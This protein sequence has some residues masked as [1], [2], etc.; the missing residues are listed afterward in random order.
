MII[1]RAGLVTRDGE[2]PRKPLFPHSNK[3]KG[4][5]SHAQNQR[6]WSDIWWSGVKLTYQEALGIVSDE[7]THLDRLS[8]RKG[9]Y[10]PYPTAAKDIAHMP[11]LDDMF[12]VD[13]DRKNYFSSPDGTPFVATEGKP[14][15]ATMAPT[16]SRYGLDDL[17]REAQARGMSKDELDDYLDTWTEGTKSGGCHI[18]LNQ[19]PEVRIERT[20]HHRDNYRVDVLANNWRGCYPS[21]GYT[22][23]KDRPVREAPLRLVELLLHLNKTLD[24]VGG[25]RMV[26]AQFEYEAINKMAYKV[27]PKGQVTG[28][29][30]ESLMTRWREGVL[31]I[32]HLSHKVGNWNNRLFWAACRYAEGGWSQ[33]QAERDII[34]AAQPWDAREERKARDSIASAYRNVAQKGAQR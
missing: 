29:R 22:V 28:I 9:A 15:T 10:G 8:I 16:Y 13:C 19:H 24:P 14:S 2:Q 11:W 21:P 30:D 3:I 6:K 32:V 33:E 12:V 20:M 17:Y 7:L 4:D 5:D 1:Y 23:L 26:S 25:K 18:V 27:A 31:S 34:C